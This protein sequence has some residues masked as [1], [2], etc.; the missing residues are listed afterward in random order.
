VGHFIDRGLVLEEVTTVKG[1]VHVDPLGVALLT[2]DFVTGVDATLGT[3][4]VGTLDRDHGEEVHRDASFGDLDR[5]GEAS[6][7]TTND[8]HSGLFL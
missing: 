2:G 4:T 7:A 5:C 3:H 6:E 8:N 1:F